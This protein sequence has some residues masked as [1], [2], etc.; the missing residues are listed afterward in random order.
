MVR[1]HQGQ[2][3]G[4]RGAAG[5]GPREATPIL[6]YGGAQPRLGCEES[7]Y[8]RRSTFAHESHCRLRGRPS[9]AWPVSPVP[10]LKRLLRDFTRGRHPAPPSDTASH[11][12]PDPED[13]REQGRDWVTEEGPLPCG[14]GRSARGRRR[15]GA[16]SG[17]RWPSTSGPRAVWSLTWWWPPGGAPSRQPQKINRQSSS[18]ARRPPCHRYLR[19]SQKS[20]EVSRGA[21]LLRDPVAPSPFSGVRK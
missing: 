16:G 18:S 17:A 5:S 21:E 6:E 19:E 9:S 7:V 3:P 2:G 1:K 8:N 4:R 10:A 20:S 14:G 12:S 11:A 13:K 15:R